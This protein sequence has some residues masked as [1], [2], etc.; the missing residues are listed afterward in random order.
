MIVA[1]KVVKFTRSKELN[2][3]QFHNLLNKLGAQCG[4]LIYY[5]KA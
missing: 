1:V 5:F 4:D 3:R 2:H